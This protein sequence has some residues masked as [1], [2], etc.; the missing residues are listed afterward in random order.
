[1]HVTPNKSDTTLIN[2]EVYQIP[3]ACT[4]SST[5]GQTQEERRKEVKQTSMRMKEEVAGILNE[6]LKGFAN[7]EHAQQ[8]AKAEQMSE[9]LTFHELHGETPTGDSS[10][11]SNHITK[12]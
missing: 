8:Q 3:H 5:A 7:N 4:C 9:L 2:P 10:L 1:M 12:T 6:C 11:Q